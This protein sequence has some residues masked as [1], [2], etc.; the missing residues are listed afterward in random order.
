MANKIGRKARRKQMDR[1][2][3]L[4]EAI[5]TVY[6]SDRIWYSQGTSWPSFGV[7]SL[8]LASF[9]DLDQLEGVMLS[10]SKTEQMSKE[11]RTE[12]SRK[13]QEKMDYWGRLHK[14]KQYSV[15]WFSFD[16]GAKDKLTLM[17]ETEEAYRQ[18]VSLRWVDNWID[19]VGVLPADVGIADIERHCP[20]RSED[21]TTDCAVFSWVLGKFEI[22]GIHF[23]HQTVESYAHTPEHHYIVE[24]KSHYTIEGVEA[25]RAVI[26]EQIR[27]MMEKIKRAGGPAT[28]D[29]RAWIAE[30]KSVIEPWVFVRPWPP[31]MQKKRRS[32]QMNLF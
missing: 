17:Q 5:K 6:P 22:S 3:S 20:L 27:P 12:A 31:I 30:V 9:D 32:G 19:F 11:E 15:K 24:L 1:L 10:L 2:T 8:C 28:A 21:E 29:G 13:I 26:K 7:K 18:T 16:S 14:E 23:F 25:W 4:A